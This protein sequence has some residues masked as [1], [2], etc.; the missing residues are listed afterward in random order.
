MIKAVISDIGNVLV[1]VDLNLWIASFRQIGIEIP[2]DFFSDP[3]FSELLG[4]YGTG[5]IDTEAFKS[6]LAKWAG[7]SEIPS[8]DFVMAWNK[9]ILG[10]RRQNIKHL[11]NIR[12]MGYKVFA[13]SDTNALHLDYIE[14]LYAADQPQSSFSQLFDESYYSHLVS[15][16]KSIDK[17]WLQILADHDLKPAECLFIDDWLGNI[18]R[19]EK[20]GFFVF[21]FK[22]EHSMMDVMEYLRLQR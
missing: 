5:K 14:Q 4:L 1:S 6:D 21:H 9:V 3:G 19:A 18:E 8:P 22:P 7:V 11:Q 2:Q 20:L 15:Y 17:A 13:L 12:A 16:G 10:L